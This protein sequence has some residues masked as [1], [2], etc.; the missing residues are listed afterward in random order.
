MNKKML[1]EVTNQIYD[2]LMGNVGMSEF[3]T[4]FPTELVSEQDCDAGNQ[5]IIIN[6]T[7]NGISYRIII[8]ETETFGNYGE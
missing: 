6:F 3:H 2:T 1:A 5:I 8:E 7:L 4:A